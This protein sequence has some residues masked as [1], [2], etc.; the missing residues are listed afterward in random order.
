MAKRG[1]SVT[2]PTQGEILAPAASP[3]P[4]TQPQADVPEAPAAR[5]SPGSIDMNKPRSFEAL[6]RMTAVESP[7]LAAHLR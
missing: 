3:I 2:Q 7:F 1:H 4:D 5:P 6:H